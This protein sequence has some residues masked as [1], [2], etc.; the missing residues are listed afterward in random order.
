MLTIISGGQT[1]VDQIALQVA[2]ELGFP[3]GGTAPLGYRT[4]EGPNLALRDVYGLKESWSPGYRVRT[5]ANICDADATI[6]FGDLTSPGGV[7]TCRTVEYRQARR[8]ELYLDYPW[9][10]NPTGEELIAL[11]QLAIPVTGAEAPARIRVLN[12]AGNR[13]RTNPIAWKQAQVVL[14]LALRALR[15]A[16]TLKA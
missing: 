13:A 16:E 5:I 9:F 6:W 1:G 12:V 4:D 10:P 14:G 2:R 15:D 7:L 11:L 8:R 3:T